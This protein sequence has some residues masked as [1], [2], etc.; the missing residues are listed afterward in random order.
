MTPDSKTSFARHLATDRRLA[1]LR[2][3]ADSAGYQT[4]EY[5]LAKAMEPQ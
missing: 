1:L 4:N 2:V 5:L 3:L